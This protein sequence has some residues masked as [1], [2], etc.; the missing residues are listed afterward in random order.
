MGQPLSLYLNG[1]TTD[2]GRVSSHVGYYH[3]RGG[4]ELVGPCCNFCKKYARAQFAES[5]SVCKW[6]TIYVNN[7]FE[8]LLTI[9]LTTVITALTIPF[10]ALMLVMGILVGLTCICEFKCCCNIFTM[11]CLCCFGL[12]SVGMTNRQVAISC[13]VLAYSLLL[14]YLYL[15]VYLILN[16]LQI[17]FP[18][19]VLEGLRYDMWFQKEDSQESNA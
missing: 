8:V 6:P 15:P 16:I 17:P 11:T 12:S 3:M 19:L 9:V 10:F 2:N 4:F 13:F 1:T 18:Y 5:G 14:S 7:F